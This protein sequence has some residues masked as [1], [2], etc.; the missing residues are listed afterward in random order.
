[1]LL[2]V[3]LVALGLSCWPRAVRADSP[4]NAIQVAADVVTCLQER[5]APHGGFLYEARGNVAEALLYED[6]SVFAVLRQPVTDEPQ[7]R[8]VLSFAAA[9]DEP[10]ATA[11]RRELA[12]Y[13][14][15]CFHEVYPP[16]SY[17]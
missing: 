3:L 10:E 4:P 1:M 11:W 6:D 13:A 15:A 12:R 9:P 14:L 5:R 7:P 8:V 16:G 2:R 17:P